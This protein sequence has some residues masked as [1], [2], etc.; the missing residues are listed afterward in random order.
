[1]EDQNYRICWDILS[2][3]LTVALLLVYG[4][5]SVS[6]GRDA[7]PWHTGCW[8]TIRVIGEV[9]GYWHMVII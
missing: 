4:E 6:E 1:M 5:E 3:M 7:P 9:C 8:V 2:V